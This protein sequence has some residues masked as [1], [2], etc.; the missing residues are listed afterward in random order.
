MAN[1]RHDNAV[2]RRIN[3]LKRQGYKNVEA[4]LPGFEPPK[5]IGKDERVPD[6]VASKSGSR[7]IVEF[8][9][10]GKVEQHKEQH[11]TFRRHAA[12]KP[13]TTFEIEE[14]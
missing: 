7:K 6:I 13:R 8:E 5:P 1:T 10:E 2:R 3:S 9:P 12:Q 11:A 4:A 14:F